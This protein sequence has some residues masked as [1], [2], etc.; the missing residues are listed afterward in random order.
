MGFLPASHMTEPRFLDGSVPAS[1]STITQTWSDVI[2]FVTSDWWHCGSQLIATE[3]RSIIG[4]KP[5]TE[6]LAAPETSRQLDCATLTRNFVVKEPGSRKFP[7]DLTLCTTDK[8]LIC[9][10]LAAEQGVRV[11]SQQCCPN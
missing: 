3:T 7:A 9:R 4:Q 10:T 6:S 2:L 5:E 8:A 11:T 1:P